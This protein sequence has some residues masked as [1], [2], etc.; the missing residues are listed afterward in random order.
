MHGEAD[1][2]KVLQAKLVLATLACLVQMPLAA[3]P[4][5]AWQH[6][7]H[8][9]ECALL[10]DLE[11]L[12]EASTIREIIHGRDGETDSM[13][14]LCVFARVI[15]PVFFPAT[16]RERVHAPARIE[17]RWTGRKDG[18]ARIALPS[19]DAAGSRASYWNGILVIACLFR[20]ARSAALTICNASIASSSVESGG[21]P[22]RMH[23]LMK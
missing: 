23:W 17:R 11:E 9:V 22:R 14:A 5:D 12:A 21:L 20:A 19:V 6:A 7:P 3:D 8:G 16:E 4:M 18:I 13:T 1:S 15:Y 10:S 2:P